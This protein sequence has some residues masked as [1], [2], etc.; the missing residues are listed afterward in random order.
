MVRSRVA[1]AALL[2]V[3]GILPHQAVATYDSNTAGRISGVLTYDDGHFLISLSPMPAGP[4]AN[5]FIVLAEVPA[6]GRQALLSRA[7]TAYSKGESVNIGYDGVTCV[8][9]WFRVHRIG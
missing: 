7:L 8:N 3:A 4:C 2:A 1:A 6:D 9:G 5:Y